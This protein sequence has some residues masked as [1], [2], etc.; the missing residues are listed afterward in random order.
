ML[1]KTQSTMPNTQT[2][3][4]KHNTPAC[5]D[6]PAEAP[7]QAGAASAGRQKTKRIN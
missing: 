7:A 2:N 5:A 3:L 6:L 1:Y 4:T